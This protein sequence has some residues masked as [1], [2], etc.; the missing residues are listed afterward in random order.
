MTTKQSTQTVDR[1]SGFDA[2]VEEPASDMLA[3]GGFSRK[4][5]DLLCPTDNR[6]SVRVGLTGEWGSGKTSVAKWVDAYAKAD[7]HEVVWFNPWAITTT[8]QLWFSFYQTLRGS[9]K[10]PEPEGLRGRFVDRVR[11][12]VNEFRKPAET[13]S[14]ANAITGAITATVLDLA[15][16][17][18]DE[19]KKLR[20]RIGNKRVIVIIDDL[21]R[22]DPALLAKLLLSLRELFDIAGFSFLIPFDMGVV[23]A[24]P[25][26]AQWHRTAA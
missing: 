1:A 13:L 17:T 12:S 19:I 21:D 15:K 3:R 10:L 25:Q 8:D 26:E 7:G 16:I 24:L 22:A 5:Y 23:S 14:R 18:P 9:L 4:I 6:F 11:N 2:P 20:S